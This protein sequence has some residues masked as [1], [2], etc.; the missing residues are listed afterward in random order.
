MLTSQSMVT[1]LKSACEAQDYGQSLRPGE[2]APARYAA[3]GVPSR[4]RY[5]RE[6]DCT[7]RS[8]FQ[9]DRD[10]VLHSTAFRRLTYKTQVFLPHE[11]DHFRTRLTHS[12]EVAQIARTIARQLRLDEDLAETIALAHDL[13]HSPFG[14]AGERAIDTAMRTFGGFD[15]NAQSLR[16]VTAL[17]RKY[18]AFDGLNLTWETLEGLAKHNGPVRDDASPIA[19]V[20]GHIEE[21]SS[22]NLQQWPSAEAQVASLADDI[23]YL[24]H[25][26]DDGLR[27]GLITFEMLFDVPLA[28]PIASDVKAVARDAEPSRAIYEVT[29]RMITAMV[30]DVVIE[31]RRRL[32]DLAPESPEDVRRAGRAVIA[33]SDVMTNDLARLK[34]FLFAAV[35]HNRRVLDVMEQAEQVVR[36]LFERYASDPDALPD[37]WREA[38]K[39]L[40]DRRRARLACDFLAGQ[41]DRYAL[42]EHRRL[43]DV[44]PELG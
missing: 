26:V 19:K 18:L 15:H 31:S 10:R 30:G 5:H 43:F 6:S 13:G 3:S 38:L 23:A 40:D 14:H 8:P 11:G 44:T 37:G 39:G 28:G 24:S 41:T 20:V 25:D 9:R 36:D 42:A 16:I 34:A 12:L 33:F 2:R 17:E 32:S 35:Y 7:T 4:G 29:R 1:G 22:L 21:W 27:A